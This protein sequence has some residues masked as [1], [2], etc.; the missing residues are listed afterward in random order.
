MK[1]KNYIWNLSTCDCEINR[2]SENISDDLVITCDGNIDTIVND[3][4]SETGLINSNDQKEAS[5]VAKSNNDK[6][7]YYYLL[8][9]IFLSEIVICYYFIRYQFKHWLKQKDILTC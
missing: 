8:V 9:A 3:D 7:D 5:A 1:E 6:M 4:M 2:Y